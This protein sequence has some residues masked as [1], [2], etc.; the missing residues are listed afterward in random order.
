MNLE[1]FAFGAGRGAQLAPPVGE[2]D[3]LNFCWRE[4][5]SRCGA[6]RLLDALA[7]CRLPVA[8]LLNSSLVEHAPGLVS[9]Y[10]AHPYGCELVGHGR[11]NA[12][13][14]GGLPEAEE[15]ALIR[16]C[17]AVL[18]A[19]GGRP[20]RGWLSPWISESFTTPDLLSEAGYGYSL[21]WCHDDTPTWLATRGGAHLAAVPYPQDGLNDIPALLVRRESPQQFAEAICDA[22][23]EMRA[24]A[25]DGPPLVL[26]IAL[27][28][29]IVGQPHRLGHLRRALEYVAACRPDVWLTT[30]GEVAEA[31]AAAHPA[32]GRS[33]HSSPG[34]RGA[35]DRG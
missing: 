6:F 2:P 27:H 21:N 12:E 13:E 10:L 35:T 23:D 28:P 31:W 32:G 15:A 19:L 30:P 9:A 14:Q 7:A 33:K 24:A 17:T 22:F 29:Y 4:W 8:A 16:E 18:A 1:H 26:G 25:A 34:W 20:P 11:T 3:V 5:G